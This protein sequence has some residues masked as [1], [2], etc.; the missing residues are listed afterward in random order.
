MSKPNF[1]LNRE[2][3]K[4]LLETEFR[5]PEA[6]V[7][8][9][10]D[11][12]DAP[13]WFSF[14]SDEKTRSLRMFQQ[15]DIYS[16]NDEPIEAHEQ[17]VADK[18][19]GDILEGEKISSVYILA[20]S[21]CRLIRD[22]DLESVYAGLDP[23]EAGILLTVN[24]GKLNW[25]PVSGEERPDL[26]FFSIT[27][28]SVVTGL[29]YKEDVIKSLILEMRSVDV[30][31][32]AAEAGEQDAMVQL[33]MMYLNGDTIHDVEPDPEKSLYWY[34]RLA[35]TGQPEAM[36]NVGLAYAKG[37]GAPR[38]F[39]QAAEWMERAAE[40]GDEDA[41]ACAEQ[42]RKVSENLK[43]ANDGGAEAAAWLAEFF[44]AH[45]DAMTQAGTDDDYAQS[46]YWAR[47]AAR[48]DNGAGYYALGLAY[49]YG[50][51]VETD[52]TE[53]ASC[54]RKGADLGHSGCMCNYAALVFEGSVTGVSKREAFA[55][56][57]Q[58][59]QLGFPR[60]I[61]NVGWCYQFGH[62]C[63]GN[64]KKALEWYEKAAEVM[65]DPEVE[66]RVMIFRNLAQ[67]DPTWG[68]DY[69]GEDDIDEEDE[70]DDEG[71]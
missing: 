25:K 54:F 71:T 3:V 41:A 63:T 31:T 12:T 6:D 56:M 39:D 26:Q 33:A 11:M 40:A 35:R 69:P 18:T 1:F 23:D 47:I 46:L 68:E 30:L 7:D 45:A 20:Q 9:T 5:T 58:S 53:A 22:N 60:A 48:A 52:V 27:G 10:F 8:L 24:D 64:M 17:L 4:T 59:A 51:G 16:R 49:E 42:Y 34:T 61:Y 14:T 50:R 70:N 15:T 57:L 62:G 36:F 19:T 32:E 44:M 55:M 66:H 21:L 37:H 2:A 38:D 43:K 28:E 29:P 67:I 13:F 65:D